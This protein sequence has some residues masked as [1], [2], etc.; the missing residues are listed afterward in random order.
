M[1]SAAPASRW[2][3]MQLRQLLR[4]HILKFLLVLRIFV[5]WEPYLE[6]T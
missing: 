3:E 5:A 2:N 4:V 6:P 1:P